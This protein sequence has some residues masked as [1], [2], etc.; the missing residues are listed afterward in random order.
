MKSKHDYNYQTQQAGFGKL[1]GDDE[2]LQA[3]SKKQE[4]LQSSLR[5]LLLVMNLWKNKHML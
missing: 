1:R 5:A 4:K 3:E 2:T